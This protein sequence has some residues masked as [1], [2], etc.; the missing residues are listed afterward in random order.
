MEG[1]QLAGKASFTS[2]TLHLFFISV[3]IK[4]VLLLVL[5][6]KCIYL[7]HWVIILCATI[8]MMLITFQ[9]KRVRIIWSLLIW[10]SWV[11]WMWFCSN[12]NTTRFTYAF[13][14]LINHSL[15]HS[16]QAFKKSSNRAAAQ[17]FSQYS[18]ISRLY[19]FTNAAFTPNTPEVSECFQTANIRSAETCWLE[20]CSLVR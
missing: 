9:D 15:L 16:S 18:Y 13:S 7:N 19:T 20:S 11:I 6:F 3:K 14:C 2:N 8:L 17:T 12:S 1:S 5:N 10:V 4:E